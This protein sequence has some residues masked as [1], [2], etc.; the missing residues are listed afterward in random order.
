[1]RNLLYL[2]TLDY[3]MRRIGYIVSVFLVS[4]LLVGLMLIGVLTSDRVETAAVQAVTAELSQ[5]LGTEAH[6]GAVEY[7]FPARVS[8]RDVYI[9]DRL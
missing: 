5:A 1:M 9:E 8:V 2:C 3:I 6:V 4:L 7:R